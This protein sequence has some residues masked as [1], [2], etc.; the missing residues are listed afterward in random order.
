[1][2][3]S[4]V[5]LHVKYAHGR[6]QIK[7]WS[8]STS[9][10]HVGYFRKKHGDCYGKWSSTEAYSRELEI[11]GEINWQLSNNVRGKNT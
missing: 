6:E 2:S 7:A 1:M 10:V 3:V 5:N 9:D 4:N 11:N 8:E